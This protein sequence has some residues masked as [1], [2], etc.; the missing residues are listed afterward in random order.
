MEIPS[1]GWLIW[2]VALRCR[3]ALD[4]ALAP[5]GLTNAQYGLLAALHGLSRDGGRPSQRQLA[6]FAG[7][8]PMYVSKLARTLEA[9]GLVE[10]RDDPADTRAVRLALTGRGAEVLT[11]ARRLVVSLDERLLLPL[12]GREGDDTAALHEH[13]LALLRHLDHLDHPGK[14]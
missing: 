6:D 11:E 1:T 9:A 10:R 7:L 8:E 4:R 13:L 12:G 2:Q 14:E 5:L 3:T